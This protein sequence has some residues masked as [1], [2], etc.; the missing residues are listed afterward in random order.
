MSRRSFLRNRIGDG[1]GAFLSAQDRRAMRRA[2]FTRTREDGT[3]VINATLRSNLRKERNRQRNRQRN[4]R[5]QR[6]RRPT[7]R[8]TTRPIRPSRR[9]PSGGVDRIMR[10]HRRRMRLD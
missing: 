8:S 6:P 9:R 5:P 4:E 3:P 10:S 7:R 1:I 2:G